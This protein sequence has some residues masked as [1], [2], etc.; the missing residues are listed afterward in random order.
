MQLPTQHNKEVRKLLRHA[1]QHMEKACRS[2]SATDN[3]YGASDPQT[4]GTS[5]EAAL[6]DSTSLAVRDTVLASVFVLCSLLDCITIPPGNSSW[7]LPRVQSSAVHVVDS[8][9]GTFDAEQD[10]RW[11]VHNAQEFNF[12]CG[13]P[14]LSP[15]TFQWL[16]STF[17]SGKEQ[18]P[19]RKRSFSLGAFYRYIAWHGLRDPVACAKLIGKF[20]HM[21][22]VQSFIEQSEGEFFFSGP[23]LSGS[24]VVNTDRN[25]HENRESSSAGLLSTKAKLLSTYDMHPEPLSASGLVSPSQKV[26]HFLVSISVGAFHCRRPQQNGNRP[27]PQGVSFQDNT[28][29]PARNAVAAGLDS[30]VF[31]PAPRSCYVSA[32]IPQRVWQRHIYAQILLH[33]CPYGLRYSTQRPG[34]PQLYFYNF[35]FGHITLHAAAVLLYEEV[36]RNEVEQRFRGLKGTALHG[37]SGGGGNDRVWAPVVLTLGGLWPL[38]DDAAAVLLQL[39]KISRAP[40]P[41][42]FEHY[43]TSLMEDVPRPARAAAEDVLFFVGSKPFLLDIE[44]V[45]GN[46]PELSFSLPTLCR[47]LSDENILAALACHIS[48]QRVV[49]HS[50]NPAKVSSVFGLVSAALVRKTMVAI[51]HCCSCPVHCILVLPCLHVPA[52]AMHGGTHGL[53]T[54]F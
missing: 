20:S 22:T 50:E 23:R 17:G 30:D 32:D 49:F 6:I 16:V 54:S 11:T 19:H 13:E 4:D 33:A 24:E 34:P 26:F 48:E 18:P 3:K 53:S 52:C 46:R 29:A 38:Y 36:S 25:A 45:S 43:V 15:E 35:A 5:R 37:T 9:F 41:L 12:Y 7:R 44:G 39:V 47:C 51:V 27:Q 14:P 31:H 10:K 1:K 28:S 21:A 40:A 2:E 42:P 8:M